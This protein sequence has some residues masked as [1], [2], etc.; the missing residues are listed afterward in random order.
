[1]RNTG[2]VTDRADCTVVELGVATNV[3]LTE[4]NPF[5]SDRRRWSRA[6]PRNTTS[7]SVLATLQYMDHRS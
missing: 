2:P 5:A 6:N 7:L 3:E 1:M 4:V